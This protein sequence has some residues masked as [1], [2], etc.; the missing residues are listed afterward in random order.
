[1]IYVCIPARDEARTL[2]V[3]LWKIRKVMRDFG[4]DYR[5]LVH[6]DGSE[7]GTRELLER[8]A[9]VVPLDV[10]RSPSARGYGASLKALLDRAAELSPYPKRDVVV[11]LQAD[12]SESPEFVVPMIKAIEG[13]AD[14]VCGTVQETTGVTRGERFTRWAALRLLKTS[15]RHA[16]VPDPFCGLRAFRVIVLKKAVRVE[17]FEELAGLSGPAVNV[18]LLRMLA[19]FARRI[20]ESP[21]V[22]RNDRKVRPSRLRVFP[23]LRSLNRIRRAEWR[24][25]ED[26][27]A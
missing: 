12:F 1:M 4:R 26:E 5:I 13:G 21:V 3:L 14:L 17:R 2:G 25:P 9:R 24:P 7:D 22:V 20:V 16:P 6:D 11:T 23:A 10:Q 19:P 15:L 8:Y 18:E 27:A